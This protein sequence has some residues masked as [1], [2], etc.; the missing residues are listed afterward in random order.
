MRFEQ[1]WQLIFP[2]WPSSIR[3]DI[4]CTGCLK[5]ELFFTSVIR[6]R[7]GKEARTRNEGRG[8]PTQPSFSKVGELGPS[9]RWTS[10]PS[11]TPNPRLTEGGPGTTRRPLLFVRGDG[12]WTTNGHEWARMR[13]LMWAKDG[14]MERAWRR[15]LLF[16]EGLAVP[17]AHRCHPWSDANPCESVLVRINT[18]GHRWT[19]IYTDW[20][21][22]AHE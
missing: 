4:Q 5:Y 2:P 10:K 18:D 16:A 15:V 17:S 14:A 19:R 9:D 3:L 11:C 22:G 20:E 6:G 12:F 1:A 7:G 8:G 21:I 13:G